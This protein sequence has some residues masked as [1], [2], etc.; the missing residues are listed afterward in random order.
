MTNL[1]WFRSLNDHTMMTRQIKRLQLVVHPVLQKNFTIVQILFSN[2]W[3][4]P[5][6]RHYCFKYEWISHLFSRY[7]PTK[8]LK[9][10][11]FALHY[12]FE[13]MFAV[14]IKWNRHT[15]LQCFA[16]LHGSFSD[17]LGIWGRR[18]SPLVTGVAIACPLI[19]IHKWHCVT[20]KT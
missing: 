9:F 20:L 12:A 2:D 3:V 14:N 5:S 11:C 16:N 8:L 10:D 13:E 7:R 19:T 6:T 1:W 18:I 15:T 17:E 4:Q